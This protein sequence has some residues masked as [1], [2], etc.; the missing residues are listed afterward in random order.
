M[1]SISQNHANKQRHRPQNSIIA[2]AL[3]IVCLL[4]QCQSF[5]DQD[6]PYASEQLWPEHVPSG[7]IDFV[8]DVKPLLEDQCMECHNRRNASE[9][10]G[11][12]LETRDTAL[13]T[14]RSAPVIVP[15]SPTQ[16]LLIQVLKLPSKHP[17]SMPAAPE[18]VA[19]VRLA[20][21]EKWIAQGAEW[22][23]EVRLRQR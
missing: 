16:S 7:R 1:N 3:F 11:L 5:P 22:P 6:Q 14:G 10:A 21:L 23:A 9:F 18:K 19:G 12:N 2:L 17:V 15:G 8:R 13:T 20:I 4:C